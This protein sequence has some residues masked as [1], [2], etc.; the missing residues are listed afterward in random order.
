MSTLPK[1]YMAMAVVEPASLAL[2]VVER[3]LSPPGPGELLLG[4]LHCGVCRTDLHI[5]DGDLHPPQ[6]PLVPGHEIV[7]FVAAYTLANESHCFALPDRYSDEQAA[8]LLCAGLI[9]YRALGMAGAA[10]AIGI[11]GFGVAG[12]L[13]AQVA[14]AGPG[15]LCVHA[16]RDEN[17]QALA[18]SLGVHWAGGSDEAPPASMEAA[19]LFAPVGELVARGAAALGSGRHGGVRRHPHERHSSVPLSPAVGR[20]L[21]A[22]GGESHAP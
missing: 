9:G 4:V 15:R 5:V 7:G 19:I 3:D 2:H 20:A 11:Y 16:P 8:P 10:A 14:R 17:A 12:H 6:L 18:R 1:R 21:R 13:M 22:F